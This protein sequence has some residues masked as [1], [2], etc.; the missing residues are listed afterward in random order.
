MPF[1][2][3]QT[4]VLN[5]ATAILGIILLGHFWPLYAIS[6]GAED[7]L[8]SPEEFAL[9]DRENKLWRKVRPEDDIA[10][11][12][13]TL[14]AA[15]FSEAELLAAQ[16][17]LT[18]LWTIPHE[19]YYGWLPAATAMK[20]QAIDRAFIVQMR[21]ALLRTVRGVQLDRFPRSSPQEVNARWRR[22]ILRALDYDE[23]AEFRLMNSPAARDVGERADAFALTEDERRLLIEWEREFRSIYSGYYGG[24]NDLMREE[25]GLDH[26]GRMRELLG[27]D[28]F[29]IYLA[30]SEKDFAKMSAR[31]R[32]IPGVTATQ[33]LDVWW[34]RR[35]LQIARR[36][37]GQWPRILQ[38]AH[39]A[40]DKT[41]RL[42][43]AGAFHAFAV[44][45]E[46]AWMF[47]K[48]DN[49]ATRAA[50]LAQEHSNNNPE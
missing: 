5:H 13:S 39:E 30:R 41:S 18:E 35:A 21:A 27:D 16:P 28:R 8:F 24:R 25:A 22:E 43:H 9:L 44:S 3:H 7:R 20:I 40:E 38:L 19:R 26:W 48:Q 12:L 14:R 10:V 17:R 36:G 4:L 15:G 23:I 42:L 1:T 2:C 45:E 29:L 32:A 34:V 46:A 6:D 31:L 37:V 11:N 47:P 33:I 50:R 49:L